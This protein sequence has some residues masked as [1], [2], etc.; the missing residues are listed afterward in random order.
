MTVDGFSCT[1]RRA[2]A[3]AW[4][5]SACWAFVISFRLPRGAAPVMA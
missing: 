3:A 5:S 1:R 2:A 4:Y